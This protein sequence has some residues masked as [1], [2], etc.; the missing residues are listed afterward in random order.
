MNQ[1]CNINFNFYLH[2]LCQ[3]QLG[4]Q[5]QTGYQGPRLLHLKVGFPDRGLRL[6]QWQ[7]SAFDHRTIELLVRLKKKNIKWWSFLPK[8]L[9]KNQKNQSS[10]KK[11]IKKL[12]KKIVNWQWQASAFDHLTI[13][14]LVRL[15]KK[16]SNFST[17]LPKNLHKVSKGHFY[18]KI[19]WAQ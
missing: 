7:A 1:L 12:V 2:G 8:N 4:Q 15:K 18:Q 10:S 9:L 14:L 5:I 19:R 13:E 6:W 11:F 16:G 17:F 3:G